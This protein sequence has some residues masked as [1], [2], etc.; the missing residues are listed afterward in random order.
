MGVKNELPDMQLIQNVREGDLSSFGVLM[1]K[2]KEK[3]ASVILSMLGDE[4]A[5]ED[6]GQEVFIRFYKTIDKFKGDSQ[7]STYLTR[8]AINLSIN[9]IKRRKKRDFVS[10][11]VLYST[12]GSDPSD[13]VNSP[14]N[15][16]LKEILESAIQTLDSKYRKV[17]VLR[18]VNG[19]STKETAEILN[20]PLG[21]VLSRL[22]R[23]QKKLQVMLKPYFDED[24]IDKDPR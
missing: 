20:I 12:E 19:Y 5:T 24:I 16:D 8:I 18:L 6:V 2:H 3:V 11:D 9:E 1:S 22:A 13:R 23:G 21:T 15:R 4:D 7:L 10:F 17:V 14:E